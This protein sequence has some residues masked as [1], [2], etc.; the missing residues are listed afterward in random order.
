MLIAAAAAKGR[1]RERDAASS[2]EERRVDEELVVDR[3][4]GRVGTTTRARVRRVPVQHAPRGAPEDVEVEGEVVPAAEHERSDD[5]RRDRSE[6]HELPDSRPCGTEPLRGGGRAHGHAVKRTRRLGRKA[7]LAADR[8]EVRIGQRHARRTSA[9]PAI[10][11]RRCSSASA[12]RPPQRLRAREV[13]EDRRL[14]G[15]SCRPS[16]AS[17]RSPRPT[18]RRRGAASRRSRTPRPRPRR[19]LPARRRPRGRGCP[20]PRRSRRARSAGSPMKTSVPAG[21]SS[22][23][24]STV[25]VARP[26]T[27]T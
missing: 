25:K 8:V 1:R 26:R 10:A 16:R 12:V 27:T 13:V 11:S 9:S 23:S 20:P 6:E 7:R 2:G 18:A 15:C 3:R 5:E 21:A 17:P 22:V 19:P 14:P 24:P 4:R